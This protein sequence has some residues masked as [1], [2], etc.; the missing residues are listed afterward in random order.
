M[1]KITLSVLERHLWGAADILRGTLPASEFR[2]PIM[3][4]LFL[5]R[6][7][8]QFEEKVERLVANG[9]SQKEALKPF[10]HSFFV[11][12]AARWKH[13]LEATTNI[14]NTI[15]A[16][17]KAIEGEKRNNKLKGVLTSVD[18]SD[19]LKYPDD[20]L[21]Q[22]IT[23]FNAFR[24]RNSDFEKE[25]IFGDAYEFLLEKFADNT[26]KKGGEFFT[27]REVVKL[28]VNLV[29]PQEGM[30]ICDP[31]CGSGGML[32]VSRRY[33][34]KNG[35]DPQKITLHGQESNYDNL[36]MCKMNMV[37]HDIEDFEIHRGDVLTD[38]KLFID[39][40]LGGYD[41]VLANFPFSMKNWTY[42]GDDAHGRFRFG[43]PTGGNADFA[44]I[45]HMF[46]QLNS[47]GQA[48][49]ICSQG[50]LSRTADKLI[51]KNMIEADVVEGVIALP[52]KLFFGTAIAAC[53]LLL[54]NSKPKPRRKKI[55]FVHAA[56]D[57]LVNPQRNRLRPADIKKIVGAYNN[58]KTIERYCHVAD[59]SEIQE[60]DYDLNVPM[61]VDTSA[62]EEIIDIQNTINEL[63]NLKKQ[64]T[65]LEEKTRGDLRSLRFR[66]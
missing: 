10:N 7:N 4:I 51:R 5:K 34:V 50:V 21:G 17:C 62:P 14:G 63:N 2:Q 54:R 64:R 19:H 8:D 47:D 52:K 15:N 49:I 6:L 33:V 61:Y 35:G 39:K 27:P 46:S 60:N 43:V 3:A 55:I 23:H 56:N 16:A 32:I 48:A 29:K 66:V 57:M 18:Y 37:L 1:E 11:P 44:F 31:T 9:K 65:H 13:L 42:R 26:K 12:D 36:A 58:F 20:R 25:D 28:L 40:R 30:R 45:Q 53:V 41:R 38:P 24:L 59:I 22:L